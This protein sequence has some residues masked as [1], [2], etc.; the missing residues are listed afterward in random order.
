[1]T[2]LLAPLAVAAV[3]AIRGELAIAP[4][5]WFETMFV[6]CHKNGSIET[7]RIVRES[8]NNGKPAKAQAVAVRRG[9]TAFIEVTVCRNSQELLI[10]TSTPTA[11]KDAALFDALRD[12]T[13]PQTEALRLVFVGHTLFEKRR[14]SFEGGRLEAGAAC[15]PIAR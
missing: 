15:V 1:M 4:A 11:A 7:H 8:A 14:F 3:E 2:T 12:A 13:L 6:V 5:E 10:H 9:A